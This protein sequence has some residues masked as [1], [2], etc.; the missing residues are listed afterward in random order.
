MHWG[1]SIAHSVHVAITTRS[2]AVAARS[3]TTLLRAVQVVR[4][5][6]DGAPG[7]QSLCIVAFIV[8]LVACVRGSCVASMLAHVV[9]NSVA[10]SGMWAL[11]HMDAEHV[12][13]QASVSTL[14]E[15]VG[16]DASK[17]VAES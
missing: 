3:C 17:D 6:F 11:A 13:E 16:Q 7:L 4:T 15:R 10:A 8:E 5:L 14:E 1:S 2:A 9:G 12:P